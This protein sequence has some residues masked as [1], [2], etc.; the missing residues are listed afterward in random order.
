MQWEDAKAKPE[1]GKPVV[2]CF[3]EGNRQKWARACWIP[4]YFEE[5]SGNYEGDTDYD[6]ESDTYYWPE[7]WYEWNAQEETHWILT[8][9]VT[10]WARVELPS[11]AERNGSRSESDCR[12][13]L[14]DLESKHG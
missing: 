5:D 2:V 3:M 12:A 9:E 1:P 10:H 7:G 11:N 6:E 4:K 14:G 13:K 8:E